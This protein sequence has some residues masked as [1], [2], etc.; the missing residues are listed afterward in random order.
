MVHAKSPQPS[1]Q[2][3]IL[4]HHQKLNLGA[5]VYLYDRV[6]DTVT[7]TDTYHPLP[8]IIRDIFKQGHQ[9][10][11][12]IPESCI[13]HEAGNMVLYQGQQIKFIWNVPTQKYLREGLSADMVKNYNPET[14]Q[15]EYFVLTYTRQYLTWE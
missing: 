6:Y 11:I 10:V 15:M 3:F 4:P 1:H 9:L 2:D 7:Q 8:V 14:Q 12:E 5:Q 13:W